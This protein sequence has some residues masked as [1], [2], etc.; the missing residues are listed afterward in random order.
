[1]LNKGNYNKISHNASPS[2]KAE[3]RVSGLANGLI[4][5]KRDEQAKVSFFARLFLSGFIQLCGSCAFSRFQN[6]QKQDANFPIR[7]HETAEM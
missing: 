5:G 2:F 1:M 7:N 6:R 4:P 3:T